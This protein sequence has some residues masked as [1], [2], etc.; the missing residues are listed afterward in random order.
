L[1]LTQYYFIN[2]ID[3]VFGEIWLLDVPDFSENYS[4]GGID[5][6]SDCGVGGFIMLSLVPGKK[7]FTGKGIAPNIF[8]AL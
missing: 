7:N 2:W 6:A 4:R 8:S 1:P 5:C 3:I